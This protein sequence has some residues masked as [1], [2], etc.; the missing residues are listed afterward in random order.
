[1]GTKFIKVSD[2]SLARF[3]DIGTCQQGKVNISY[4]KLVRKLDAPSFMAKQ[5]GKSRV[6]WVLALPDGGG[7]AVIYDFKQ[8][9]IP[10]EKVID[11]HISG[12]SKEVVAKVREALGV[13]AVLD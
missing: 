12:H 13:V 5:D 6:H 1:M 3:L 10:I 11:W 7:I 9:G 8:Y 4:D 2:S